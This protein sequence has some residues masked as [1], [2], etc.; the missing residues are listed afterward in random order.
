MNIAAEGAFENIRGFFDAGGQAR[1]S[2]DLEDR[3]GE[4]RR[5]VDCDGVPHVD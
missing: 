3:D 2:V 1:A 4:D 5:S